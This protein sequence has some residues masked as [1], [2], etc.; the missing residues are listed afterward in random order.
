MTKKKGFVLNIGFRLEAD[1]QKFYKFL[2]MS[3]QKTGI[4]VAKPIVS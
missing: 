1:V 2:G 3:G 4:E